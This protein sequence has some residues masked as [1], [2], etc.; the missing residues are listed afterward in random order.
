[1]ER[2]DVFAWLRE[3]DG[4]ER[5][6]IDDWGRLSPA[7]RT[8]IER[9]D[10][11]VFG[12]LAAAL[13]PEEPSADL[14]QRIMA[15]ARRPE[16]AVLT[17][18]PRAPRWLLPLAAG[19]TTLALGLALWMAGTVQSQRADL[20][21]LQRQVDELGLASATLE[22]VRR[23]LAAAKQNLQL[24]GTLG[25]EVC[26]LRPTAAEGEDAPQ[27]L[28]FLAADHQHWYLRTA[29]L[30]AQEGSW[31]RVWFITESGVVAAG[32]LNDGELDL[33]SPTMPADTRAVQVTLET[34]PQP[35]NP[36]DATVLFGLGSEMIR[37]L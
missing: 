19:L 28:L 3:F 15:G 21:R 31:Y 35:A 24:V 13:E 22:T 7:E 25:V 18:R 33:G 16:L 36:S 9:L 6:E 30:E 14:K 12:L 29:G 23:D 32:N 11:E 20:A 4:S 34:E 10:G 1:M 2:S 17:P 27:G 37:L 26:P 5:D 8:Q